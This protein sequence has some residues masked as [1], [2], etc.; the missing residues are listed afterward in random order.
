MRDDY[1]GHDPDPFDDYHLPTDDELALEAKRIA[2]GLALDAFCASR[3][4]TCP[5]CNG[6]RGTTSRE[7]D[8]QKG[9]WITHRTPCQTCS[10]RGHVVKPEFV[11][12]LCGDI[13][14][15]PQEYERGACN[16]CYVLE[17]GE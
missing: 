3:W 10:G 13:F 2:D 12:P 14:E 1:R 17:V 4:D 16:A 7:W 15:T 8:H 5:A 6:N 9:G 11:C